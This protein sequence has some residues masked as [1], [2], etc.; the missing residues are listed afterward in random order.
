MFEEVERKFRLPTRDGLHEFRQM[1]DE[2]NVKKAEPEPPLRDKYDYAMKVIVQA[3]QECYQT[4]KKYKSIYT[5]RLFARTIGL[6]PL[7]ESEKTLV[8]QIVDEMNDSGLYLASC[9]TNVTCLVFC[10]LEMTDV[11]FIEQRTYFYSD[12]YRNVFILLCGILVCGPLGLLWSFLSGYVVLFFTVIFGFIVCLFV[13]GFAM[14]M[15]AEDYNAFLSLHVSYDRP[16]KTKLMDRAED[17]V[18]DTWDTFFN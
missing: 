5:K 1:Y 3:I 18:R 4:K 17:K 7:W 16:P 12:E 2:Q 9:G 6:D 14:A 8:R 11:P 13:L 10:I 15:E